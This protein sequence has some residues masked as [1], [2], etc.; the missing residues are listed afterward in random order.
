VTEP[1]IK[2]AAIREFLLWHD[3]RYGHG[4]TRA[5]VERVPPPLLALIDP[6]QPALGILGATWYPTSLTHPM[7]DRLVARVGNEGRELAREANR[8]VVPRMIRGIYRVLFRAAASP[9][10]YARHVPRLWRRLH[11]TGDRTMILRA[12]GEILSTT[13]NWP[14]H[15]PV[16]CWMTIYTMAQVFEAMG[17]RQWTVERLACVGHGAERCETVLRYRK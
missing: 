4:E 10:L 12:P 9:E 17:Y 11:T 14:G 5:L 13:S 6:S 2:G 3:T 16:L 1:H 7:L 8:E 15:H